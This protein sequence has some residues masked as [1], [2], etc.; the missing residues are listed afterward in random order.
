MT[1]SSNPPPK[2][3]Q[4]SDTERDRIATLCNSMFRCLE[5]QMTPSD[6][7]FLVLMTASIVMSLKRRPGGTTALQMFDDH[8]ATAIR[9]TIRHCYEEREREEAGS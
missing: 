1:T 6:A 7:L 3:K 5:T 8:P 2:I 9:E 4:V